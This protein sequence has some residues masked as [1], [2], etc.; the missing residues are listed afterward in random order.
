MDKL[1]A[2]ILIDKIGR[3]TVDKFIEDDKG[4]LAGV[5]TLSLEAL[6]EEIADTLKKQGYGDIREWATKAQQGLLRRAICRQDY[7]QVKADIQTVF[8]ELL[9]EV[10]GE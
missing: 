2:E 6:A 4:N 9:A 8:G 7:F 1:I 3:E 10:T 5:A